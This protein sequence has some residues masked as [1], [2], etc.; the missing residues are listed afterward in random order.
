MGFYSSKLE[1]K[2]EAMLNQQLNFKQIEVEYRGYLKKGFTA[3]K[4]LGC[5][6]D[7]AH[8]NGNQDI[9]RLTLKENGVFL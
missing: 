3:I 5:L 4:N 1:P 2:V 6:F 9:T 8:I 7:N